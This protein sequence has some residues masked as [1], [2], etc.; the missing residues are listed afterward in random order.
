MFLVDIQNGK[1]SLIIFNI[2]IEKQ[3]GAVAFTE[4]AFKCL[5]RTIFIK[6]GW[7]VLYTFSELM[8]SDQTLEYKRLNFSANYMPEGTLT[9]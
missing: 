7:S 8:H 5:L 3:Q 2:V 6:D 9:M 4:S 1:T